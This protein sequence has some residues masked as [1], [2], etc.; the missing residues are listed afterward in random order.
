MTDIIRFVFLWLVLLDEF[1]KKKGNMRKFT[2]FFVLALLVCDLFSQINRFGTPTIKNYSIQVT[3]G[4]E[5]NWSITKDKAGV[6]YLANDYKGIIRYDGHQWSLIQ[7]RKEAL[8][9]TLGTDSSGVI[10]VGGSYE[11]GYLECSPNGNMNYVSISQRFEES[12]SVKKGG[13]N[14]IEKAASGSDSLALANTAKSKVHIGEIVSMIVTDSVVYFGSY[15]SLFIYHKAKDSIEYINLRELKLT[16]VVKFALIGKKIFLTDNLTGLYELKNG[17]PQ[18]VPG[19]DFFKRKICMVILP[20]DETKIF[21]GTYSN[22]VFLFDYNTGKIS[23]DFISPEVNEMLKKAII[24]TSLDLPTGERI[25]GTLNEGVFVFSREGKLLSLWNKE[26]TDLLDNTVTSLYAGE[27]KN[28]ELWIS[29]AGYISTALINTPF[30]EF[31]PRHGYEGVVNNTA[32]FG[33]DIFVSTDLGL[34]K[35][36]ITAKGIMGFEKFRNIN[37]TVFVLHNALIGKEESLLVGS[38]MGLFQILR[39]GSAITVDDEMKYKSNLK[40]T[41]FSIRSITQSTIN[42]QRFYIGLNTDGIAVLDYT[43]SEWWYVRMVK[44][45]IKGNV[46]GMIEDEKGDMFIYSGNPVGLYHLALNDTA[47]LQFTT[48]DGLPNTT[49][50]SMSKIGNEIVVAT[51]HGLYKYVPDRKIWTPSDEITDGYTKDLKCLDIS[52]DFDNDLWLSSSEGRVYDILLR[53][54]NGK[55]VPV[56]GILN[57]LPNLDKMDLKYI[58]ERYWMAKSKNIYVI[59]KQKMLYPNP[60]IQ[61]VLSKIVIG[62]DS[63]LMNGSFYKTLPDGKRVPS[64]SQNHSDVPEIK[65]NFNSLSFFWTLPFFVNE[66]S[67][68]YSYKLEGFSKEW[69]RWGSVYYKDFTNLPF[70]KYT[71]RVKAKT[72]TEIESAEAVYEFYILKPWYFTTLMIILYALII[73]LIIFVIIKAY[74]RKLKNE[75]V[76]L[77][78]IVSERTAVVVKQKEELE[79]SIHYASRIQMALLPSEAILQEN[80]KNYFI[81]FKPRD[82]VSG[83]FYWMMKKNERL[84]VVA[85]DCTGHG[86]PGAFMSL[87]GMSFLDEIIDKE[88]APRADHVLSEL[89]LHV[90][91][92]LKQIGGDDEAKD[93]M[94]MS[95]LVVDFNT[96]RIEFSGAY[97]PCFRVRKL[98]EDE[99]KNFHDENMEMPDGTMSNGKYLLETIFASKMPIGISSRMNENFA[100]FDWKLEKGI[101]YYLFSDGYIDQFGGPDGRK[102]MKKNFKRLLLEIQDYPMKK[103]KELLDKNLKEWMGQSPQIDDILVMGIRTE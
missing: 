81:L 44:S 2:L 70:G 39:N 37:N 33:N 97:N 62:T 19:G 54:V 72:A 46:T 6:V 89:R 23:P 27:D 96:S 99:T 63:M 17:K 14:G 25:L 52:S 10:Y 101:S 24:Y 102:F 61:T 34:F 49:Y 40:G 94:D 76:R 78:G 20:Y 79:S 69:S 91:E 56:K 84:Y 51:G 16:Q 35:S 59:D 45:A 3:Q 90:T 11:F 67:T 38:N 36:T 98:T 86:V 50:Y 29:T 8:A 68:L 65:Y 100:F 71:F 75:N 87:L 15:E 28:S 47:L 66:E 74:T 53:K 64:V 60:V 83:D 30:T 26:T 4:L 82:I 22:G 18:L 13:T 73:V 12:D 93:G 103:Q 7:L 21:I 41:S 31:T 5:Y 43:N 55:T 57:I 32:K 92:S 48:S 58:D 85:A 77:E 42:P 88:S 9:R 80:L 1:F 95:L